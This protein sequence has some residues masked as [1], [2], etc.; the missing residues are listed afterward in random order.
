MWRDKGG[1]NMQTNQQNKTRS[2]NS[3]RLTVTQG[4]K[5]DN[6]VDSRAEQREVES[7]RENAMQTRYNVR[8]V[9]KWAITLLGVEM[10]SSEKVNAKDK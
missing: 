2:V 10:K 6:C 3:T 4:G 7:D 9:N 8:S 1:G 5:R